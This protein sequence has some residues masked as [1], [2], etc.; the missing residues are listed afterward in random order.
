MVLGKE[1]SIYEIKNI[2]NGFFLL[3]SD[4]TTN[5]INNISLNSKSIFN[6]CDTLFFAIN[7]K[8]YNSHFFLNEVIC[9]GVK[10]IIVE[11]DI[12]IE[13][14]NIN[15]IKVKNSIEA[16]QNLAYFHKNQFN[17]K[18][19]GITGSNG[20]TIIKEW[21][22]NLLKNSFNIVKSPKS[23]NSQIGVPLSIFQISENNTLGIFEAGISTTKEMEKLE[24]IIRPQIGIISNIGSAHSEGFINEKQKLQEKLTLFKNSD[25]IIY[26]YSS[27]I[28]EELKKMKNKTLYS[29]GKDENCDLRIMSID[30]NNDISKV[31]ISFKDE[32]ISLNIPFSNDI[33][34]D[35]VII[36]FLTAK[37]M[38]IKTDTIQEDINKLSAISMR[39]EEIKGV[40]NCIIINDSYNSDLES[41]KY[42][43]DFLEKKNGD[44]TLIISDVLS[45]KDEDYKLISEY[46]NNSSIKKVFLIGE[47]IS[48]IKANIKSNV[49]T[50]KTTEY[51]LKQLPQNNFK[52]EVILLKG[53]RDFKFEN[54]S[55]LLQDK[56]HKT[57][58]NINLSNLIFNYNYLKSKLNPKTKIMAMVKANSYGLGI[59]EISHTLQNQNIDYLGV[60]Y[61]DEGL[62]LRKNG[63][64]K[65]IIVMNP[66]FADFEKIISYNLEPVIY[67]L[68]SLKYF[69]NIIKRNPE[70]KGYKI[71]LEFDSGMHRLGLYKNEIDYIIKI[72]EEN[73][74]L[75]KIESVFSHLAESDNQKNKS[76]T[77][78][79][80]Y[81]FQ[82]IIEILEKKID[83]PFIKHILNSSGVSNF[84]KYQMDMVRL[85]ISLYGISYN[86]EDA[87]NLKKTGDLKTIIS[88]IKQI[89][90]GDSI[91]Y[92][93]N[94]IAQKD[95]TI[96]ILPIGYADG[97]NRRFSNK[98][99]IIKINN[100][101]VDIVG[102]ICMDTTM[103]D[104]SNIS[105]KKNDKVHI[106]GIS[107]SLINLSKEIDTIPYEIISSI[108]ERVKRVYFY[109]D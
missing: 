103:V 88:Q 57:Y 22:Y 67:D 94:F 102:N 6:N 41:I 69:V 44:K 17:L 85:G 27:K 60:A 76:F 58:L 64:F 24:K 46:I 95:M 43:L 98:K 51:F 109:E 61:S 45:I 21:L 70:K 5:K 62:L 104:I 16:L 73:I 97:F 55:D 71:H 63:I 83:T 79:Q 42:S 32:N 92:N 13:N 37:I 10:N 30:K 65:P 36:C 93:R 28:D 75:I 91:S 89:K 80:I 2:V 38:G 31:I 34:I 18:C 96:A 66:N 77:E 82:S 40:N 99:S 4:N 86:E 105:C 90:K 8:K 78:N 106:F 25:I 101:K 59:I 53:S 33:F 12:N 107:S 20:K 72:I 7:G 19:I 100:E 39:M 35:N 74:D 15:V 84:S 81:E 14:K 29:F 68:D 54:I 87:K 48:R 50:F 9:Q 3:K 47:K 1:Y 108:S 52:N 26:K 11:D 23:Y 56:I 49:F